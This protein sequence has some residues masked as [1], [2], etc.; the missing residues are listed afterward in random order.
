MF[1]YDIKNDL[2]GFSKDGKSDKSPH[3]EVRKIDRKI[4]NEL[5]VKNH[6]SHKFYNLSYIHF[7]VFLG[8]DKE[9]VMGVLQFGY[10]MNPASGNKLWTEP[11]TSKEWLELN[12]MWLHDDLPKNTASRAISMCITLIKNLYPNVKFIQSFADERCKLGGVVYQACSFKYYGEH[13]TQFY[14][15]EGNVYHRIMVTSYRKSNE[16]LTKLF[17]SDPTKFKVMNLRQFRYIFVLD[18]KNYKHV[19]L[20][21]LDYPK[22]Y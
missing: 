18:S 6:Y 5:I 17:K 22:L 1:V 2:V 15:Y 3:L 9:N 16:E 11:I 21:Q 13:S 14:E 4:A 12:R 20:K 19:K 8:D 10:G 7:G